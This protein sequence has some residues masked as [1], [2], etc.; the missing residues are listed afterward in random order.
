MKENSKELLQKASTEVFN[1]LHNHKVKLDESYSL[2]VYL[3]C[4]RDSLED[5]DNLEGYIKYLQDFIQGINSED[6]DPED[7]LSFDNWLKNN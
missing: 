5:V 3:A 1:L 6:Y 4:L 2:Q 7:Y